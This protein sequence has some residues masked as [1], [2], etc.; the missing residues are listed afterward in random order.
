LRTP[1]IM[2]WERSRVRSPQVIT[3]LMPGSSPVRG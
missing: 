1:I 2:G 3:V